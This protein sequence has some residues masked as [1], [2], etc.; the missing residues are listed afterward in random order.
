MKHLIFVLLCAPLSGSVAVVLVSAVLGGVSLVLDRLPSSFDDYLIAAFFVS[1][2]GGL[3]FCLVLHLV[4]STMRKLL[5]GSMRLTLVTALGLAAAYYLLIPHPYPFA[6]SFRFSGQNT[7]T[8]ITTI[9]II[10]LHC[11]SIATMYHFLMFSKNVR[12]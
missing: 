1:L 7:Y 11:C 5:P 2:A 10:I 3:P 9:V 4:V 8:A 12:A 6:D